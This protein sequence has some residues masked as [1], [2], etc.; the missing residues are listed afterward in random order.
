MKVFSFFLA[1]VLFVFN[2]AI[3]AKTLSRANR[4]ILLFIEVRP[5][6]V[7]KNGWNI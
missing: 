3:K 4:S 5:V 6:N 7:V 1:I 2:T